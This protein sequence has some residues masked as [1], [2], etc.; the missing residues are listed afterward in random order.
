MDIK[1]DEDR[2]KYL[3]QLLEDVNYNLDEILETYYCLD[4]KAKE[5]I[6]EKV[7]SGHLGTTLEESIEEFRGLAK[8][9]KHLKEGQ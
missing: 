9:I 4:W 5:Y 2:A 8:Y 7:Y 1:I 6:D 3:I